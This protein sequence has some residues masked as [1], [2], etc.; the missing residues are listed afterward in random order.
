MPKICVVFFYSK[1]RQM[2]NREIS[3]CNTIFGKIYVFAGK[4]AIFKLMTYLLFKLGVLRPGVSVPVVVGVC[5]FS[6]SKS[7]ADGGVILAFGAISEGFGAG[8]SLSCISR[9]SHRVIPC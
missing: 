8:A 1:R 9:N 7:P 5:R 6:E 3:Y 4:A 2:T